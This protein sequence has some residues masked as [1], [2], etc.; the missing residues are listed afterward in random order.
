M[1]S[2]ESV[3]REVD[4]QE[5][6]ARRQVGAARQDDEALEPLGERADQ[7]VLAARGYGARP[8]RCALHD[9]PPRGA[10]VLCRRAGRPQWTVGR[11]GGAR[12]AGFGPD[13][14]GPGNEGHQLAERLVLA[15]VQRGP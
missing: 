5:Q 10:A 3:P 13:D 1:E 9:L 14:A 2:R 12:A 15:A 7:A 8:C 6:D 4:R 11:P